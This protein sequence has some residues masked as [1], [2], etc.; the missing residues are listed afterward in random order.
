MQ[1]TK[2]YNDANI[3]KH[4]DAASKVYDNNNMEKML[5][6][7]LN[8]PFEAENSAARK[9]MYSSQYQQHVCLVNPEIPY[10]STGYEN[11]FGQQ[12]SSFVKSDRIWH[13]FAKIE[14]FSNKPGHHYFL[15]VMD[16]YNNMD[17]I[18]RVSYCHDTETYG[19]LYDNTF[20]DSLQVGSVIPQDTTI[21]KSISFDEFDNYRSGVNLVA[22]YIADPTTTEDAIKVSKTASLKLA[23]TAFN[24][25]TV[26]IN[27]NEI[28]LNLNGDD[29]TYKFIP[30]IGEDVKNGILCGTRTE[31]ND[32]AFFAQS[33]ERLK[34]PMINDITFK[35]KGKVIDID[36]YCN[37]DIETSS[38]S[39]YEGQLAFYVNDHKRF[40]QEVVNVLHNFIDNTDYY[41]SYRL[42]EFYTMCEDVVKGKQ[43][44]KD[45]VFSNIVVEITLYES[46]PLQKGDK[47][48][49]RFGGKGVISDVVEDTEMPK[50]YGTDT[51][52]DVVWNIAT[53]FNRENIG[54]LF[55]LSTNFI[56]SNLVMLMGTKCFDVAQCID[57]VHNFYNHLS[58]T[59]AKAFMDK[60]QYNPLEGYD[61]AIADEYPIVAVSNM[62]TEDMDGL[63]VSLKP[64]T[65]SLTFEQLLDMYS[66]Y[67]WMKPMFL[68]VPIKGS[69]GQIRYVQSQKPCITAKQ[70]IYRMKQNAEEKHSATALSATNIRNMNSKSKASK[71]FMSA[72]SNTPIRFGEMEGNIF[73]TMSAEIAVINMM[74]Y[75]N[76]PIGRRDA[77]QMLTSYTFDVKLSEDA[78]SRSAEIL[79]S[80]IKSMGAKFEFKKIPINYA[81]EDA[82]ALFVFQ[83][84]CK[85]KLF[86]YQDPR[87]DKLFVYQDPTKDKLFVY[88]DPTKDKLFVYQGDYTTDKLF[89]HFLE[90]WL[91]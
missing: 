36:I 77:G 84:P 3:D 75:S 86:V 23:R 4:I 22:T 38:N 2:L 10:V 69:R 35:A 8:M 21:Q 34:T 54:Q 49:S 45:N 43:Y 28:P 63:Y 42:S 12:S 24:K 52:V 6:V 73:N 5:G 32:E 19:F 27:D 46:A 1:Y 29:K 70:Y 47:I 11:L 67:S 66:E 68:A 62:V 17:V 50:I 87:K 31:K 78:K 30:D 25:V 51:P 80:T 79:N 81:T 39:I 60:I 57:M 20:L 90:P 83:D 41:K 14:K 40:C 13:V 82:G 91:S 37:K 65:E 88:Q 7:A 72:H 53:C 61:V 71:M 85:D 44:I 48:T 55:E 15:I 16:D 76:S 26:L 9:N 64:I 74:I 59:Y 33:S 18:E 56:S 89:E 58:P